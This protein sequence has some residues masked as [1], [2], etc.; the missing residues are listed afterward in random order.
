[1]TENTEKITSVEQ[2]LGQWIANCTILMTLLV[3]VSQFWLNEKDHD[4]SDYQ[5]KAVVVVVTSVSVMFC[6]N[7]IW[8]YVVRLWALCSDAE[9]GMAAW[10][11]WVHL[12]LVSLT[13]VVFTLLQVF[14]GIVIYKGI[15]R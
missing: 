13:A 4:L 7:A 15:T 6:V 8:P 2:T 11:E 10:M 9:A 5:K 14:M 12:A 1:M 3:I